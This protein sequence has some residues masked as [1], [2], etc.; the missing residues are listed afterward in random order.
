MSCRV[1]GNDHG[2]A[3]KAAS[4]YGINVPVKH[5]TLRCYG[6]GHALILLLIMPFSE[7]ESQQAY[8]RD[9]T[10]QVYPQQK[11]ISDLVLSFLF[12]VKTGDVQSVTESK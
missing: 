2:L 7:I 4:E 5:T 11:R 1:E 3:G 12:S 8:H 10:S 6:P 9:S